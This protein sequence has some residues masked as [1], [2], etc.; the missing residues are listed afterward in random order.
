MAGAKEHVTQIF[1]SIG[2][3]VSESEINDYVTLLDKAKAA[4]EKVEAM[5]GW[6]GDK[7]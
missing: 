7:A 4:F 6:S 5:G 3:E 1:T 2:Y